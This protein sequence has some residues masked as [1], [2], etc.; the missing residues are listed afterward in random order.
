LNLT[1]SNLSDK[2]DTNSNLF[3]SNLNR[4]NNNLSDKIDTNSNL[5]TSNLNRTNSN[6]SDKIDTNSNLFTS[7]LIIINS[8]LSDK[9]DTNS[10]LFTS[11]L[12]LVNSNLTY[13]INTNSNLFTS[14]LNLVNSN[15]TYKINTNSNVITSNL[16]LVNSNLNYKINTNS[17]L[18]T[19]NLVVIN[20]NLIYKIDTNSNLFTSNLNLVN[21]NLTYK[22]NTNSN[23]ITSNLNLVNSNLTYKIDTNSNVITSN[24]NL[25]NSNL[26]YKIDTNSNII[27]SMLNVTNNNLTYKIDTNSNIITSILN[28]TNSDLTYKIDTNSNVIT[29]NLNITNSNLTYKIDNINTDTIPLGTHNRFII[30]DTYDRDVYFSGV[31]TTSNLRVIGEYITLQTSVST[32]DQLTVIN[33]ST[34]TAMIV[35]QLSSNKNVVEFYNNNNSTF[36][37][38]SNANI[39]IG[40]NNPNKNYK[41]DVNGYINCSDIYINEN[42]VNTLINN[43]IDATNINL[44]NTSNLI[45]SELT[46]KIDSNNNTITSNLNETNSNF[47][48]KIDWNSNYLNTNIINNYNFLTSQID[49]INTDTIPQGSSNRFI[50]N[51]IYDS[52][53]TTFTGVV[54]AERVVSS[55][56]NVNGE[57]SI[58]NTIINVNNSVQINNNTNASAMMIS[59]MNITQSLVE[60]YRSQNIAFIIDSNGNV[61][62]NQLNPNPD[63]KLDVNGEINCTNINVNNENVIVML[64]S[65]ISNTSNILYDYTTEN[66]SNVRNYNTFAYNSTLVDFASFTTSDYYIVNSSNYT[67]THYCTYHKNLYDSELLIHAD[68]PYKIEGYGTDNYASRLE[69]TSELNIDNPEYSIEH[70]QVFVGYAAGGGTRSTTLSPINH[71]TNIIGNIVTIKVQIK[72]IDS[73][74]SLIT[75]KCIFVITEKKPTSKLVLTKYITTDDVINITSNIYVSSNQLNKVL[76]NYQ[77]NNYGKWLCNANINA[78]YADVSRIGIGISTPQ[79]E[80]DVDGI[81]N[82]N[83]LYLNNFDILTTIDSRIYYESNILD[84]KLFNSTNQLNYRIDTLNSDYIY[85]GNYNRFIVNDIY[86]RSVYFTQNLY[87]SNIIASNLSVIGDS[88]IFHTS[89]YQTEQLQIVNDTSA[90]SLV[91]KQTNGNQ[92]VAEF[93]NGGNINLIINSNGNIGVGLQYPKYKFDIS[94][95]LNCSSLYINEINLLESLQQNVYETSNT[96]IEFTSK[97]FKNLQNSNLVGFN[98]T[99]VDFKSITTSNVFIVNSSNYSNTH[100]CTYKKFFPDS[101]LLIQADFPYKINGFG[102]DHYASRLTVTSDLISEPEFSLEHEQV[103]IGYAAGG[104]TRSTTLSPLNYKT[105]IQGTDVTITVQIKLIDSDDSLITDKC[106]FIITEKKPTSRLVLSRY[107]SENDIP[108]VTSNLYINPSQLSQTLLSYES[109]IYGKWVSNVDSRDIYYEATDSKVGIGTTTPNFKLDVNGTVNCSELYRNGVSLDT[110][111]IN[112]VTEQELMAK[113]FVSSNNFREVVN[114]NVVGYN[115][116]L[117]DFNAII[118]SNVFIVNSSNYSNTHTCTYKKFFPDSELLIQAEFPYKIN[119]FGSDHY[120]SRLSITSE[121]ISDPEFS[122]E[123][124]QIFIGYAAGG[125]TR[126]TTLSPINHKTNIQGTDV[127]ISVQ[128]KLIDSDDSLI[129]DKCVFIITEKKPSSMLY[130]TNYIN[131]SDIPRLTSNLYVSH[132]K[133]ATTLE[134]YQTNDYGKWNCNNTNIYYTDGNVG[135]GKTNPLQKLDV[136]GNIIATGEIISSFSDIRLKTI[137]STITNALELITNINGFKYKPNDIAKSFGYTDDKELVGINAQEVLNYI[138]EIVSLAPFDTDIDING[139]QKSKSGQHYLTLQYEKLVPYLIEAIKELKRENEKLNNRLKRI[140]N[141]IFR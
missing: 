77:T 27:T 93:Y 35:K 69:I 139:N 39:G 88:T 91:V 45:T 10:N 102:S 109:N 26:T 42:S 138:P 60:F 90:T 7:N 98:S 40:L 37:I 120:A 22:I 18:F 20:S 126:S 99:L 68:F 114:S 113:E 30:D 72:L 15:L 125:G 84:N 53:V 12:N 85:N 132:Q 133:F 24:L 124:E 130:F 141:I 4:T 74:D 13:K 101:E 137:T 127:T 80:L 62:I 46:Y 52:Y 25:V 34:D 97:T 38:T 11:N 51:D 61:G 140:E 54:V 1:N 67:N 106:V 63:Y 56:L 129:T 59:Q 44:I 92:N 65:N 122:L 115:T 16:N 86:D 23:V 112:Y 3:T 103:F 135:I 70:E 128:I 57:T 94:G 29:S 6:L 8:N 28:V 100:T 111:L 21:S 14:N 117:V 2:I 136:I 76:D 48:Y 73:D 5:F 119:G 32:T 83:S 19:S 55:N 75:D 104:G 116:T 89:V 36:I 64:N 123:H 110:T 49:Y 78:I 31:V 41:I 107:L 50:T 118:T 79:Y 134:S 9:I 43:F 47:E 95:T 58:F 121:V 81:I 66:F 71:K 105:E 108:R 131:K 96:L 87:A 82:A 33:D 17:N